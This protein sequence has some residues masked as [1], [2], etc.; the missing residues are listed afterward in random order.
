MNQLNFF[1]LQDLA[2]V[3]MAYNYNINY[4]GAMTTR[5]RT[6][7]RTRT[8]TS[9]S[10]Y[11]FVQISNYMTSKYNIK[12]N[13]KS[14]NIF[15]VCQFILFIHGR[16]HPD[17][18]SLHKLI[19]TLPCLTTTLLLHVSQIFIST[20]MSIA[21]L[22]YYVFSTCPMCSIYYYLYVWITSSKH[23]SPPVPFLTVLTLV[24]STKWN[25]CIIWNIRRCFFFFLIPI[26]KKEEPFY[27]WVLKNK[28][29]DDDYF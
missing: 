13:A 7:T 26:F 11:Q 4:I 17:A 21:A 12:N 24:S 16:V 27:F 25:Y 18:F 29:N 8:S 6:R 22:Q 14:I 20:S 5:A 10:T 23:L 19:T 15:R 2:S 1:P 28:Y 3:K 9:Q